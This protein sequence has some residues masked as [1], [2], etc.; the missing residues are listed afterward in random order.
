MYRMSL[1]SG[2][3]KACSP[4]RALFPDN[5]IDILYIIPL[6]TR[7]LK[8]KKNF[9]RCLLQ[10]ICTI[11]SVQIVHKKSQLKKDIELRTA[12]LSAGVILFLFIIVQLYIAINCKIW[13]G[14]GVIFGN[15]EDVPVFIPDVLG[16]SCHGH[17][18]EKRQHV[19]QKMF[20]ISNHLC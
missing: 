11:W 12:Q 9:T 4:C 13:Q 3:S 5:D 8:H 20:D 7:V 2:R 14:E 1:S 18:W 19:S 6:I 10:F 16:G 15:I 17:T